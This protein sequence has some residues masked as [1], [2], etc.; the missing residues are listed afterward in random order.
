MILG[1]HVPTMIHV[2][3]VPVIYFLFR[4]REDGGDQVWPRAGLLTGAIALGFLLAAPQI[5][6]YLEYYRQSSSA[7]ATASLERA[8]HHLTVASLLHFL[9]PN[10]LG[11]PAVGFE[12]M[13]SLLKWPEADNFNEIT[14]YVGILPLFF[15]AWGIAPWRRPF[16]KFFFFLALGS[17][18]IICGVPPF[19]V[20]LQ[21]LPLFRD[22]S[23]TRLLLIVGF[24][25]AVLA[26]LGWDEFWRTRT[27]RRTLLITVG[28]WAIVGGV[29]LWF[30]HGAAPA[31]HILDQAH[32]AFLG[33]QILILCAGMIFILF[34]ALW[35]AGWIGRGPMA[36]CLIWTAVDL[37]CFGMGYNPALP[38]DL[39]YPTTPAIEWLQQDHSLFRVF[40]P[41]T[42]LAPNA[43]EAYGLSDAR[44]CDYMN[45]RRYEE[46]VT[47][48][49]GDFYFY[50]YPKEIPATLPLL[51]VKYILSATNSPLNPLF[52]ELVYSKEICIYRFKKYQ[53]RALVVFDHQVLPDRAAVLD[54]VSSPNFDPGQILLLEHQP[55]LARTAAGGQTATTN[56]D[57]SARILSYE[58]DEIRIGASL[59]RPGYLLLLDTYF[60]GWSATVNGEPTT[61]LRA[62]YNFRAVQLPAGVS[63]VSFSYR[64]QS[65]RIGLYLCAVGL[66]AI[67]VVWCLPRR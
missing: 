6:P 55:G 49:A 17:M 36:I 64:P 50:W 27:R 53:E 61:I 20:L 57:R 44:G 32:R 42:M 60:P 33:R 48:H 24:C 25:V 23:W 31:L 45:V 43:A 41:A 16:A 28:F 34:S 67:A 30:W 39:C 21:A 58:P 11:N 29:L 4:L 8:S 51:N 12:D 9:L 14:G 22:V 63:T 59:A 15:A 46:L 65:L 62:D 10:A 66:L 38:R 56:A 13:P 35:P 3:L 52:Y 5:L 1:G 54:R 19:P 47:G 7:L 40:G 18:L 26:G 37:L 2:A